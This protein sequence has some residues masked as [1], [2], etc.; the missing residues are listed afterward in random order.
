MSRRVVVGAVVAG[1]FSLF[2][3]VQF[4]SWTRHR[5]LDAIRTPS[6]WPA[7]RDESITRNHVMPR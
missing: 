2:E 7:A 5:V 1:L 4:P 6:W 3:A